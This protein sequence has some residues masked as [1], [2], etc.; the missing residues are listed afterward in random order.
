M[1]PE[2]LVIIVGLLISAGF[3][4]REVFKYWWKKTT[5]YIDNIELQLESLLGTPERDG[6]P[7]VEGKVPALERQVRELEDAKND[8]ANDLQQERK[9]AEEARRQRKRERDQ[10]RAE[11]REEIRKLNNTHAEAMRALVTQHK[12]DIKQAVEDAIAP[13]KQQHAEELRVANEN[14]QKWREAAEES[15]S[16]IQ[17]LEQTVERMQGEINALQKRDT[18]KLDESKVPVQPEDRPV[19][20][21]PEV[22]GRME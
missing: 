7:A 1:T 19:A 4:L 10:E 9:D 5:R 8:L 13:L 16:K 20:L 21:P 3:G 11:H 12:T 2:Q 22:S 6:K 14:A 15:Q 17:T 18:G